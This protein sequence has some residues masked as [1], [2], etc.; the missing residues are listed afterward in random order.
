MKRINC[1]FTLIELMIVVAIIGILAAVAIPQYQNYVA[2]TQVAEALSLVTVVK[3]A[4][5]EYVSI[6]GN[7]PPNAGSGSI[8]DFVCATN[9]C[10]EFDM[11]RLLGLE[12]N[13]RGKYV[14]KL[15]VGKNGNGRVEVHFINQNQAAALSPPVVISEKISAKR[16]VL[17]PTLADGSVTWTCQCKPNNTSLCPT[18]SWIDPKYLPSSCKP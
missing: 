16:F 8:G 6:H 17:I 10:N 14:R 9:S 4:V 18:G 15:K 12:G 2:R 13:I 5:A 7:L 11:H 1:G 3:T